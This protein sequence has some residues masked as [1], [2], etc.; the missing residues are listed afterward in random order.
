MGDSQKKDKSKPSKY[1]SMPNI[2]GIHPPA[3]LDT[4]HNIADNWKTFKQAWENYSIIM[5]IDSQPEAYKVALFLHCIGSEAVK[6]YNGLP[7][8]TPEDKGT[9]SAIINKFAQFTIG[10]M[11][12]TYER[13]LFNS[14]NQKNEESID[15]Y[16]TSLR[17]LSQTCN[18]CDCM[19]DSLIRDRIVFGVNNTA[20]RKKLLQQRKLTLNGCIDICRS[21]ETTSSQLK[22][23]AES[24]S[25]IEEVHFLNY[26]SKA[27]PHQSNRK[28]QKYDKNVNAQKSKATCKFCDG[29]HPFQKE[30]CPAWGQECRKCG[31][32]NHFAKCC[33]K[34]DKVYSVTTENDSD[35]EV[36]FIGSVHV[37]TEII[38]KVDDTDYPKEIHAKMLVKEKPVSFQI[39][40]GA[41]IN[42]LREYLLT[43]M[44]S[45]Q[46][47]KR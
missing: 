24:N 19:R 32:R 34:T 13:Y 29:L 47:P 46:R 43:A 25:N 20:T 14:R 11:N 7:F 26:K 16:V 38:C 35:S 4:K 28:S 9:L 27:K 37:N 1:R 17:T 30:K 31:G 6:I 44:K 2:Q 42:I 40:C 23:I 12:E 18:F 3:P 5:N 33:R 22:A 21:M 8:D 36:E 15:A 10:E 41:S 39:D 45:R